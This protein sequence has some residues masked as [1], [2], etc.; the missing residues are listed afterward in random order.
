MYIN[1]TTIIPITEMRDTNRM[2]DLVQKEPVF[3]TKNGH[4]SMVVMSIEYY[5][6]M[7]KKLMDSELERR[8]YKSKLDGKNMEV[9]EFFRSIEDE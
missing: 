3:V 1:M 4:G 6:T 8:Y 9:D 7:K 5:N 2:F